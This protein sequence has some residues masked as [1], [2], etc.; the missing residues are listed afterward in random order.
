MVQGRKLF[1]HCWN[2]IED[3][4]INNEQLLNKLRNYLL[5]LDA[6]VF[7]LFDNFAIRWDCDRSATFLCIPFVTQ[8]IFAFYLGFGAKMVKMSIYFEPSTFFFK[9]VHFFQ[10]LILTFTRV[11]N[12]FD[13]LATGRYCDRPATF[14]WINFITH[15]IFVF[16]R[17]FVF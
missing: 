15:I 5:G 2:N 12:P 13:D 11:F 8:I 16:Y 14:L 6:S 4:L 9:F 17:G 10:Y 3:K 7:N 1:I